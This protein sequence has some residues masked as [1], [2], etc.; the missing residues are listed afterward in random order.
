M[1][2]LVATAIDCVLSEYATGKKFIVMFSEDIYQGEL[3]PSTVID[4]IAAKATALINYTLVGHIIPL[5]P[6][7]LLHYDRCS[8]IPV[9]TPQPELLLL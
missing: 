6:M 8:S 4:L 3:C 7:A 5:P 9:G 2:A 1:L